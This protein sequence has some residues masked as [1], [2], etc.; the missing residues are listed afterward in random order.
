VLHASKA[1]GLDPT[2]VKNYVLSQ[3]WGLDL[4]LPGLIQHL[5]GVQSSMWT[6]IPHTHWLKVLLADAGYE[7]QEVVVHD[8]YELYARRPLEE[9]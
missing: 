8:E 4:D 5:D 6:H 2:E 1:W 3:E 9:A 7:V